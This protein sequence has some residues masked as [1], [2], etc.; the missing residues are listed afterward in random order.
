[1]ILQ[2]GSHGYQVGNKVAETSA[3]RV[4]LCEEVKT[5]VLYLLQVA[6]DVEYNGGLERAV[7]VLKELKKAA[8]FLE[9]EYAKTQK[10]EPKKLLSYDRLFPVLIDSF[11]AE[12]QG[13]RRVNILAFTEVDDI[14]QLVPLSN[15]ANKDHQRVELRSSAWILGRLLKLLD[16]IHAEGI[17]LRTLAAGNVLLEPKR[18]FALIFDWSSAQTYEKEVPADIRKDGIASAAAT[19]FTAM[20]GDAKTGACRYADEEDPRYVEFLWRLVCR[21]ESNAER[22]HTQFY[23]LI[24]ELFGRE[25]RPF[26]TLPL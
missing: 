4:Y 18:H 12:D 6:A 10:V 15:L 22:A 25:F 16:F 20:G 7:Y 19:V 3:Y 9:E 23:E 2:N 26:K 1:V 17:A 14:E 11:V 8:D 5:G 24:D 21:R 13:N